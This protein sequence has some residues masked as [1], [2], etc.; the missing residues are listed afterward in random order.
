MFVAFSDYL[1]FKLPRMFKYQP[2][3]SVVKASIF[4]HTTNSRIVGTLKN[5]HLSANRPFFYQKLR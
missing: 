1:T 3:E 5:E 4:V 2:G